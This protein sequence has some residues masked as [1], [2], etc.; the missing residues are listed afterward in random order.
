M[1]GAVDAV[2]AQTAQRYPCR[3]SGSVREVRYQTKQHTDVITA[4]ELVKE[5]S[6]CP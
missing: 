5:E 6:L 3:A 2:T 4:K 1:L